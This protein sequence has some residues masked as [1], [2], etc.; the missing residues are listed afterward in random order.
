M[1][2]GLKSPMPPLELDRLVLQRDVGVGR[3]A[4]AY[5]DAVDDH[6]RVAD[7]RCTQPVGAGCDAGDRV[8]TLRVAR[9]GELGA[10]EGDAHPLDRLIALGTGNRSGD[11]ARLTL[12][13]YARGRQ[14]KRTS[15]E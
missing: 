14:E 7:G 13:G 2:A 5:R 12:R 3:L 4:C 6:R 9:D 11:P 10:E 8:A 15:G 1:S